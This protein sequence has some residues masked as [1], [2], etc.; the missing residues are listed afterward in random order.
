MSSAAAEHA[1]L[2][3]LEDMDEEQAVV[4]LA[5][6]RARLMYRATQRAHLL[7]EEDNRPD[8]M[9]SVAE[10]AKVLNVSEKWVRARADKLGARKLGRH[11]RIPESAVQRAVRLGME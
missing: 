9:L 1:I 6:C 5:A 7:R 3:L 11:I 8:R 10:T 2:A 4:I